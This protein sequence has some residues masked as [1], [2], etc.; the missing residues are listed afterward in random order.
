MPKRY[1][2]DNDGAPEG[3]G[4]QE[5]RAKAAPSWPPPGG[6]GSHPATRW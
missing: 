3:G 6:T 5:Q 4:Y 2:T 1:E